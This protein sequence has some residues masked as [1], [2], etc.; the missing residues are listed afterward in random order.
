LQT[1]SRIAVPL[2]DDVLVIRCW[3]T[4][5]IEKSDPTTLFSFQRPLRS[6]ARLGRLA[7]LVTCVNLPSK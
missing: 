3:Q 2:E 6:W 4:G 5:P 1:G 7:P